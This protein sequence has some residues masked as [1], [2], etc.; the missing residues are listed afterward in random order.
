MP[1]LRPSL[2]VSGLLLGLGVALHPAGAED[3]PQVRTPHG[4]AVAK[5]LKA[6]R[7]NGVLHVELRFEA[8]SEPFGGEIVYR[9]VK[10]EQWASAF[11]VDAGDQRFA[12]LRDSA[13]TPAAPAELRLNFSYDITKNPRVGAWKGD[14]AAPPAAVKEISVSVLNLPA[15]EHVAIVD[16]P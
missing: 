15:I 9:D 8:T 3:L 1:F 16:K 5:V 7:E 10:P 2:I 11:H 14:F 6:V 4:D 13:G 12:L